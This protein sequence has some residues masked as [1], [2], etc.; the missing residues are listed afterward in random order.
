MWPAVIAGALSAAGSIHGEKISAKST[1]K[2][3]QFQ[4][5]MSN[6][7]HQ[8]QVKDLKKAGLNPIL[9][10]G[11]KGASSPSGASYQGDTSKGA[12]T[13]ASAMAA[14]RQTQELKNM[15]AM[16][17]NTKSNTY[18]T[19]AKNLT[20]TQN[21]QNAIATRANIE[22]TNLLLKEQTNSARNAATISEA[23]AWMYEGER[24]KMLRAAEK[25]TEI[26]GTVFKNLGIKLPR[27]G[28]K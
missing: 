14:R 22:Q 18:L 15:G 10:A 25:A 7:A 5:R 28:K 17:D 6:T 27:K 21:V 13:T 20:E 12:K 26:G 9:A 1:A 8:R 2:Q 19:E 16:E 11:G 4:E 24:G 23:T 3:M